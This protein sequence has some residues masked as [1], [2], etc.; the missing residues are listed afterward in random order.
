MFKMTVQYP[1]PDDV[2]AFDDHYERVHAPL[3]R[4]IPG[5]QRLTISRPKGVG[6]P[7][8][9]AELWFEDADA[10]RAAGKTEEMAATGADLPHLPVAAPLT[11]LGEVYDVPGNPV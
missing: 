9:V 7:Y 5:L 1:Q 2:A 8:L 10:F 3:A 11:F 4:Q 6:A